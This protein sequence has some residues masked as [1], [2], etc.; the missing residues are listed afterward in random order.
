MSARLVSHAARSPGGALAMSIFLAR[1]P[2]RQRVGRL[3]F[4]AVA[5]FGVATIVFGISGSF[6]VADRVDAIGRG[7]YGERGDPRI[8]RAVEDAG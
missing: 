6:P 8:A 5:S 4:G 1:H 2:P 3:M 7:R